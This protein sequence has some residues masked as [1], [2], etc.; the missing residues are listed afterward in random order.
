M[1]GCDN[2]G[3]AAGADAVPDDG[4]CIQ[5]CIG[6]QNLP[7]GE[8]NIGGLAITV[9]DYTWP[10]A[11]GYPWDDWLNIFVGT[12]T[13]GP[14]AGNLGVATPL[15][16]LIPNGGVYVFNSA[17]GSQTFNGCTS[18]GLLDDSGATYGGG[19][20]L[21]HEVGHF[22][23]L[24]HTFN[25]NLA[26]TPPQNN[27]NFGC[28]TVNTTT[29]TAT[30]CQE[31]CD[32]YTGN[33]MDYAEDDC[34]FTFTQDQVDVMLATVANQNQWDTGS[35]S[36]AATNYPAC[37]EANQVGACISAA[38]ANVNLDILFDNFPGQTSWNIVDASGTI[39]ASGSN[40]GSLPGNSTTTESTCLPDGCYTLQ[41]N[42]AF[43]NGMCPF[44]SSAEGVATFV[45]PGTLIT[46]GSIVGTLSLV[47]NPG[48]CGN[49]TLTDGAGGVLASG[50]GEFGAS[51]S[52]QFCLAGGLAPRLHQS[53]TNEIK[54]I[55]QA[56]LEVLP[57]IAANF[58]TIN[59]NINMQN[60]QLRIVDVSGKVLQQY[61]R[62]HNLLPS[63]KIDITEF[64]TGIK[65]VQLISAGGEVITRKFLKQ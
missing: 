40:Y 62:E 31:T 20:I 10:G 37:G 25:D 54:K 43:N 35:V 34:S 17:F 64:K 56:S 41:V 45:T 8:D 38:C 22:F 61:N 44:Q 12:A 5:F 42:D 28:P 21:T 51:Q 33:F 27:P 49:Y 15:G 19:A 7:V 23:G 55:S 58:I 39:V 30:G 46:P 24:D 57:S 6:D 1:A 29:C 2:F 48:L 65:F 53:S 26:D 3:G 50:G 18:G 9:G 60:A 4:A 52:N 59:Y 16:G 36:C 32:N 63:L 11:S 13:S 14:A 47:A